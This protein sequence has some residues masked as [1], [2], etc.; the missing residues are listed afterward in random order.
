MLDLLIH[1]HLIQSSAS[2]HHPRSRLR[3]LNH[4]E[5][6][7][8]HCFS[9]ALKER[10]V[11]SELLHRE[12][13]TK[14]ADVLL[15]RCH[16]H[17]TAVRMPDLGA[18]NYLTRLQRLRN[19]DRDRVMFQRH[20]NSDEHR[21]VRIKFS[22]TS[23]QLPRALRQP[24]LAICANPLVQTVT[25]ISGLSSLHHRDLHVFN[26]KKSFGQVRVRNMPSITIGHFTIG[27]CFPPPESEPLIHL[28]TRDDTLAIVVQPTADRIQVEAGCRDRCNLRIF[29]RTRT[30]RECVPQFFIGLNVKLIKNYSRRIQTLLQLRVTR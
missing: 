17:H 11:I 5:P 1:D 22:L 26:V 19:H 3:K 2:R 23:T 30:Q 12:L 27:W 21:N 8:A 14:F 16:I 13:K 20:V 29:T 7:I 25:T 10:W 15:D 28:I 6:F 9:R 4:R 24:R 18:N